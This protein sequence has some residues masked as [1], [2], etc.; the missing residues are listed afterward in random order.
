MNGEGCHMFIIRKALQKAQL[1]DGMK[2]LQGEDPY[3]GTTC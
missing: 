3:R 2:L 1:L